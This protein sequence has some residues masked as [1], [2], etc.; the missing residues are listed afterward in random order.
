MN[1]FEIAPLMRLSNIFS[2]TLAF[3]IFATF[4][5]THSITQGGSVFPHAYCNQW[6]QRGG[7]ERGTVLRPGPKGEPLG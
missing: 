7:G 6:I 1:G 4:H 3:G 2:N 5:P